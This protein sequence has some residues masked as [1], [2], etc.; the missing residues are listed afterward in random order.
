MIDIIPEAIVY[1]II[2][3]VGASPVAIPV[4]VRQ[5]VHSV[6]IVVG[7]MPIEVA[8]TVERNRVA[9]D[10]SY[11]LS[12]RIETNLVGSACGLTVIAVGRIHVPVCV[13]I[14]HATHAAAASATGSGGCGVGCRS[15]R[16]AAAGAAG[17]TGA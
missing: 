13:G 12:M 8:G 11:P 4:V 2:V 3:V 7:M 6:S 1:T 17:G 16:T 15:D 10:R 9:V 5:T 14:A